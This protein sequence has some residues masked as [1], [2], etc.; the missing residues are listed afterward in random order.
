M[1]SFCVGMPCE[2]YHLTARSVE[3]ALGAP[4]SYRAAWWPVVASHEPA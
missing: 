4:L 3:M 2:V 1:T